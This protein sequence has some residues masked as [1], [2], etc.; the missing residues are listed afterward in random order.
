MVFESGALFGSRHMSF[1]SYGNSQLKNMSFWLVHPEKPKLS[2]LIYRWIG[3][4]HQL[5][6]AV[7]GIL[8]QMGDFS[9][10]KFVGKI[11]ARQGQCFSSTTPAIPLPESRFQTIQDLTVPVWP[12][13]L[14]TPR[15]S[16]NYTDGIGS[17][18]EAFSKD[19]AER[20]GLT[21]VPSAIQVG[22]SHVVLAL[23]NIA[24]G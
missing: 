20:L 19:I 8:N 16:F 15:D 13:S 23:I 3:F 4:Y 22:E 10:I 11:A 9:D 24:T 17:I 12:K 21:F 1:L 14:S 7:K 2:E 6:A 18:R 5:A